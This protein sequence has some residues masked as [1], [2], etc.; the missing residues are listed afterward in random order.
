MGFV[1]RMVITALGLWLA[2]A[3]LSG[4]T[5][6]GD[7]ALIFSALLLGVVNAVIRPILV[8]LTLPITILS[9][10]LFLW[11]INAM[12]ILLVA[13]LVD[14]FALAGFGSALLAA[15]I[16]SFTSWIG[17]SFIGPRGKYEVIVTRRQ[18]RG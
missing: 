7:R 3:L 5:I 17:S 12:M 18:I 8:V 4:V 9:L 15:V 2:S 1:L 6:D 11:A 16:V 14:G 10:G 13:R